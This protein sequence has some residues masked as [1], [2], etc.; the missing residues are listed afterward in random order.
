MILD[1]SS[2][3]DD[4]MTTYSAGGTFYI[5]FDWTT[6]SFQNPTSV[7][8]GSS[9]N[10]F[11]GG[12]GV[13]NGGSERLLIGNGFTGYRLGLGVGSTFGNST[14]DHLLNQTYRLVT[15]FEINDG[16]A[17]DTL[18]L[19]INQVTEGTPDATLGSL[20]IDDF[21]RLTSRSG[22]GVDDVST[23]SNVR[24]ASDYNS[25][26]AVPEPSSMLLL[27]IGVSTIYIR[28]RWEKR[29]LSN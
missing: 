29:V 16:A 5:G 26:V 1:S 23:I 22:I 10:S 17:N 11:F 13:Y 6:T 15:K 3:V 12:L 28:R 21:N 25:A 8:A 7:G 4:W 9:G 18:S 19:F 14:Q 24:I 27:S 2:D 20:N